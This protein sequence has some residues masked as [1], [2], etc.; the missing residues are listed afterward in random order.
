MGN[1]RTGVIVSGDAGGAVRSL[2][3]TREE[4]EKLNASKKR[5]SAAAKKYSSS[6]GKMSALL[7]VAVPAVAV[8]MFANLAT[9]TFDA[10][11]RIGELSK[12]IGA[13]TEALSEYR[14]VA[15]LSGIQFDQLATSWQRQA[16]RIA[17]AAQGSGEAKDAIKELGLEAKTLVE[18]RPEAQFEAIARAMEDVS[19]QGDMVRLGMKFWDS[20]GVSMLQAI[21]GGTAG[22]RVMRQEAVELGRSL[23][24]EQVAAADAANDAWIRL[25]ASAKGLTDQM[26]L[27]LAPG[28][29]H[30]IEKFNELSKQSNIFA[31]LGGAINESFK[32]LLHGVPQELSAAEKEVIK[33]KETIRDMEP[34]IDSVNKVLAQLKDEGKEGTPAWKA[35]SDQL[36]KYKKVVTD[37]EKTIEKL[38]K[39]TDDSTTA[40]AANTVATKENKESKKEQKDVIDDLIFS[41]DKE[42]KATHEF[43]EAYEKLHQVV[44]DGDVDFE[45]AIELTDQLATGQELAAKSTK[46]MSD[47]AVEASA[48]VS[49]YSDEMTA[50]ANAV[51]SAFVQLWED[52]LD[53]FENFGDSLFSAFKKLLAELAHE[54]STRQILVRLGVAGGGG[55][56]ASAGIAYNSATGDYD[57]SGYMA[58]SIDM[59]QGSSESGGDFSMTENTMGAGGYG[60]AGA[61]GGMFGDQAFEGEHA[62]TGASV[63]ATIGM[64]WGPIGAIVGAVIGG[65]VGDKW[66]DHA[67]ATYFNDA[68][69]VAPALNAQRL[70]D[71]SR[72]NRFRPWE[73]DVYSEGA[74]GA[75]GLSN[76]GSKDIDAEQFR[77]ALEQITAIDDAIAEAFGPEATA[78]VREALDGWTAEDGDGGANFQDVMADRL[79]IIIDSLE[80]Q[81]GEFV[82]LGTDTVEELVERLSHMKEIDDYINSSALDSYT[83]LFARSQMTLRDQVNESTS[84]VARLASE[85]ITFHGST[86]SMESLAGGLRDRYELEIRYLNQIRS[87]QD[88]LN[89]SIQ[90]SIENIRLSVMTSEEQ[91]DYFTEQAEALAATISSLSDPE[92]VNDVVSRIEQLTNRAYGTLESDEQRG[93]VSGEFVDFLEGVLDAANDRLDTARDDAVN[94]FEQFRTR[95]EQ[96]ITDAMLSS[97][98]HLE[99]AANVYRDATWNIHAAAN[100]FA[101]GTNIDVNLNWTPPPGYTGNQFEAGYY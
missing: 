15:E 8:T 40:T 1:Y 43:M 78:R 22:L 58:S 97:T 99:A 72:G 82:R 84:S 7:K 16:R 98:R 68:D 89:T 70:G 63:G 51:D 23:S 59:S 12:R 4:L 3:L 48:Q 66:S 2:K 69:G 62:S 60:M 91:Y 14:H 18:L 100:Q 34:A 90:G 11:D 28:V 6:V 35:Y 93:Q 27:G 13:S 10:A 57:W 86:E 56:G 17:E 44:M 87:I 50:A 52:G 85:M 31:A 77:E 64:A 54:A 94:D 81:W 88:G 37:A 19:N 96:A 25:R 21:E 65:F 71:P 92:E 53:G 74:F 30:V 33:L 49:V 75:I 39:K 24:E 61:L 55:A 29:A 79:E 20:E 9:S 36:A 80:F 67:E 46:K 41:I 76:R 95:I 101:E 38:T 73:D 47:A 5:G 45:Y 26:V 42:A 32:V 83:D